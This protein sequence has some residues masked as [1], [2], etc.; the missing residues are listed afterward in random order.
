MIFA[1]AALNVDTLLLLVDRFKAKIFKAALVQAARPRYLILF[2][3]L[4]SAKRDAVLFESIEIFENEAD[5]GASPLDAWFRS[6]NALAK[7][8][9]AVSVTEVQDDVKRFELRTRTST[10]Q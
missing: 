8:R 10:M 9:V 5:H 3:E 6:G 1:F 4:E 7:D 2:S